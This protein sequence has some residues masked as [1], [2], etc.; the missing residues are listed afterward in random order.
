MLALLLHFGGRELHNA[1]G[2]LISR[3]VFILLKNPKII[4]ALRQWGQLICFP[5]SL[6]PCLWSWGSMLG[7]RLLPTF[8]LDWA[9]C[10]GLREDLS[11][12]LVETPN[13]SPNMQEPRKNP[14][15]GLSGTWTS[16]RGTLS[17]GFVMRA[18][19]CHPFTPL[20]YSSCP[21]EHCTV[22]PCTARLHPRLRTRARLTLAQHLQQQL[23]HACNP[24][25]IQ[26]LTRVRRFKHFLN[27]VVVSTSLKTGLWY[28][29]KWK[30][31][32]LSDVVSICSSTWN[33]TRNR[34]RLSEKPI[35]LSFLWLC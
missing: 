2:F 4:R 16:H 25:R 3:C 27:Y 13:L 11:K 17:G 7:A 35:F 8:W 21:S 26:H 5:L 19:L 9:Y 32:K 15:P 24:F 28:T 14:M 29:I 31:Y 6:Q 18:D 30:M 1:G 12:V 34:R 22:T 10:E 23:P 20:F 33:Y